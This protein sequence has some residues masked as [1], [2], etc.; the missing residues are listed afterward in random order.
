MRLCLVSFI[1]K[2]QIQG[3]DTGKKGPCHDTSA[4]AYVRVCICEPTPVCTHAHT[5]FLGGIVLSFSFHIDWDSAEQR[6][7]RLRDSGVQVMLPRHIP[8]CCP[9]AESCCGFEPKQGVAIPL[10]AR[11]LLSAHCSTAEQRGFKR[12]GGAVGRLKCRGTIYK[13]ILAFK[14]HQ[15][16]QTTRRVKLMEVIYLRYFAPEVAW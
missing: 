14:L 8:V 16:G 2:V 13:A 6:A 4:C 9:T 1:T 11:P 12:T 7:C 10:P 3:V 15:C 5:H